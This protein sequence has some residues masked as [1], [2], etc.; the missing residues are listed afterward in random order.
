MPLIKSSSQEA[1][2][3]N[4]AELYHSNRTKPRGQRRS[5]EEILAICY[6]VQRGAAKEER[7]RKRSLRKSRPAARPRRALR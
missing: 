5:R 1:F 4:V 7:G 2:Q 3:A 6:R